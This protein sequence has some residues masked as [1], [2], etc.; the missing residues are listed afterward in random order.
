MKVALCSGEKVVFR[1]LGAAILSP[2]PVDSELICRLMSSPM[3]FKIYVN[4]SN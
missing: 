2:D 1:G 3:E 4:S